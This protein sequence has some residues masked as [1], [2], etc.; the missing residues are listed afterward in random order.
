MRLRKFCNRCRKPRK[1]DDEIRIM[2]DEWVH[3][4]CIDS[5]Y[6]DVEFK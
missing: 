1:K 3:A 4:K 6:E 5:E 2:E